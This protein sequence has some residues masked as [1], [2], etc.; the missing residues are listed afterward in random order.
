MTKRLS[1][2]DLNKNELQNARIQNLGAAPGSPVTGQIYYDTGGNILYWWNGT[3]W[4][5]AQGSGSVSYG[6]PTASAV[7]D[8]SADGVSTSVSRTDHK[9]A[10][11]AFGAATAQTTYGASSGNG[12]ATTVARS[13]HT[14]GTPSLS[15][16][17][18]STQAIGDAATNGTGTAPAKDDH[19]HAMP[20]FGAVTAQTAFAAASGNGAAASVARSDHTHGT[21]THDTAAHSAV[22]ISGLAVPT[23]D[24]PWN[25]KKITGL[26]DPT[27]AQDAAT[28]FYVDSV[29]QGLDFKASVRVATTAAITLATGLENTDVID[30]IT[31]ATGD[32]VLVKNQAAPAENGI[33]TVNASGAPT[34]TTDADASGELSAGALVYV[35]TG[36]TQ[37]ATQWIVSS[38][39]ATPWVPGSSGSTWAQFSGASTATA[40]AGLTATGNVLAVGAGAGIS[41]AADTVAI[42]TAV[43]VRKYAVGL[44]G[45]ATSEVITHNLNSQDV[46][47]CVYNNGTPWE[48]VELDIEHTSVNTITLRGSANLPAGYRVVVHS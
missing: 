42:D 10:R 1:P 19:K 9:H 44:T 8:V 14:H 33:Y 13:D 26:L 38:T 45:G 12:A 30:G 23:A 16:N 32:R 34:R 31:L 35:E 20:A 2:L 36:T 6:S 7:G 46:T 47:V 5:A 3:S 29:A 43:V 21:P 39:T 24:V 27:S 48:E 11:E 25:A 17:V 41:V 18:A 28:K 40:G 22:S 37:G 15:A 4:I